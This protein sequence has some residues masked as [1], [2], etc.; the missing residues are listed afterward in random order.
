MIYNDFINAGITVGEI[1]FIQKNAEENNL[2]LQEHN[3]T[4]ALFDADNNIVA[5]GLKEIALWTAKSSII[6]KAA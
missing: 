5:E 6:K 2:E 1:D 4:L 3:N